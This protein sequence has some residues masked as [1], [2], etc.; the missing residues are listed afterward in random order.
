MAT[1]ADEHVGGG[2]SGVQK[3][4]SGSHECG[5]GDTKRELFPA[6]GGVSG[7][8]QA[9]GGGA[10]AH[11]NIW[12]MQL[13]FSPVQV[14]LHLSTFCQGF[15]RGGMIRRAKR[16]L[17]WSPRRASTPAACSSGGAEGNPVLPVDDGPGGTGR[18]NGNDLQGVNDVVVRGRTSE[19]P[20]Q[21]LPVLQPYSTGG[22]ICGRVHE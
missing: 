20:L 10:V 2:G 18:P 1:A 14:A 6:S 12:G 4:A 19:E 21:I 8:E 17:P 5:E 16:P 11:P 22:S 3:P 7:S 9:T 15:G 13:A